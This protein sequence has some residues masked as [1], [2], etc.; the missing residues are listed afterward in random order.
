MTE[1]AG[2]EAPQSKGG[3]GRLA[4]TARFVET[5][6]PDRKATGEPKYTEYS[7]AIS[8]LRLAVQPSGYRSLIVRYRRP[9]DGKPAKLT[10]KDGLSLAA[11]RHAAAAAMLQLEQGNDPS[12]RRSPAKPQPS[13]D[14]DSVEAAVASF[15]KLHVHRKNRTS[16]I[17]SAER[18]FRRLIL[19]AWKG[20]TIHDIRRRDVVDLAETIAAGGHGYLANRTLSVVSKFFRWLVARD[21][22]AASPAVGVERPHKEEARRRVLTDD[23]LRALWRVCGDDEPFGTATRMLILS[24][25]RRGEV[26]AMRWSELDFDRR[27]WVLPRERTKNGREFELP[28]PREAWDIIDRLPQINGSDFVF[29]TTGRSPIEGSWDRIKKQLSV[30]AGIDPHSWRLHDLR[31][32]C[33]SGMQRLGTR[34][35]VI[36]RALNH[37]TGVFRGVTSVYQT[38]T[39]LDDVRAGLQ[40]WADHVMA[41][42]PTKVIRLR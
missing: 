27:I 38:D 8:P 15:L 17:K 28:L 31:R 22:L 1:R 32:S 39:L 23:E 5:A 7:D 42:K 30:R 34:V 12:P 41:E 4:F 24:G 14:D 2:V 16:T 29:T 13:G 25:A 35:E 6:R 11:A 9:N 21:R 10:L 26:G 3:K 19:P 40:R 33:A 37:H 36:E 20:R 18:V